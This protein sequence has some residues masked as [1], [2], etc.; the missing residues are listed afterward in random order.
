[1]TRALQMALLSTL[2]LAPAALTENGTAGWFRL[3][4]IV[5]LL[6]AVAVAVSALM[7]AVGRPSGPVP[8]IE[9]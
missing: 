7:V 2:A 4:G 5:L 3:V 8:P 1:M 9:A 6:L